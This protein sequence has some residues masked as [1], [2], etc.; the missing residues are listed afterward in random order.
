MCVLLGFWCYFC[1]EIWGFGEL[2]EG[3]GFLGLELALNTGVQHR[4][5][6]NEPFAYVGLPKLTSGILPNS[7]K[8]ARTQLACGP[9]IH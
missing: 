4:Q 3:L 5:L 6:Q 8:G 1:S 7:C 2:F 9:Y